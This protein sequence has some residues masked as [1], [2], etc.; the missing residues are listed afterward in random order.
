MTTNAMQ[1]FRKTFDQCLS[2]VL[3]FA[4]PNFVYLLLLA[5]TGALVQET[6]FLITS[7]IQV[8]S[9]RA[10]AG[11]NSLATTT[12]FKVIMFTAAY[13]RREESSACVMSLCPM[14]TS[15]KWQMVD[16]LDPRDYSIG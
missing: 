12:V 8:R 9:A 3:H 4:I 7:S 5:T 16:G 1:T 2:F 15:S 13:E 11:R 10:L 6:Y 14:R